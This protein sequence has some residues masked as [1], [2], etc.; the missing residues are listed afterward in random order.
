MPHTVMTLGWEQHMDRI[1]WGAVAQVAT[2]VSKQANA[3]APRRTGDLAGSYIW[4][5]VRRLTARVGS[6][7][8]YARHVELGTGPHVIRARRKKAL[9]FSV[10]GPFGPFVLRRSV[11]HPGAAAQ[12]HLRPALYTRRVLRRVL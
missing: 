10:A 2:D 3:T 4:R 8:D 1:T 6:H 11:N 7:L 9:R 5:R 12:P